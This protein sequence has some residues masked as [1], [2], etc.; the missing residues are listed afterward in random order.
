MRLVA[1]PGG[2]V[3]RGSRAPKGG[4]ARAGPAETRSLSAIE[5]VCR[6]YLPR[7]AGTAIYCLGG[8]HAD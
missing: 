2:E 6:I 5:F 3:K 7:F 4:E 1:Q 8:G